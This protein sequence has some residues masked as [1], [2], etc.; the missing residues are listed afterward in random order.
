MQG[1]F[2]LLFLTL[3]MRVLVLGML[4]E[5]VLKERRTMQLTNWR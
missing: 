4:R 3:P 1:P 2:A 5:K